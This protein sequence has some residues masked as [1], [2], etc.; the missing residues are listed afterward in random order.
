MT[1]SDASRNEAVDAKGRSSRIAGA[2]GLGYLSQFL[3]VGIGLWLTPFLLHRLGLR[4][5][6]LWLLALQLTS[7]LVLLDLG[8][9][10]LLPRETAYAVGRAGGNQRSPELPLLIGR[11][12]RIVILQLPLVAAIA[13]GLLLLLPSEWQPLRGPLCLIVGTFVAMFPI[14]LL[15]AILQGLQ[16]LPY[17]AKVSL[18]TW[19]LGTLTTVSLVFLHVG[20]YAVAI[21]WVVSQVTSALLWWVR[22]SFY[23]REVLPSTIPPVTRD[24]LRGWVR[25]GLWVSVAQVAQ[26]L[27]AGTDLLIIGKVLGPI[28]VVPYAVTGKLISV[29]AN[30]PQMVMQAAQPA[31]SEIKAT[32]DE[33]HRLVRMTIALSQ[34]MLLISGAVFLVVVVANKGFVSWW[35]DPKQYAGFSVTMALLVNMMLR[36]WNTTTVYAIFAFGN[37]RRIAITTLVD[38]LVTVVAAGTLVHFIGPV[39]AACGSILG[40]SIVS[41]PNNLRALVSDTNSSMSAVLRPLSPWFFRFLLLVVATLGIANSWTPAAPI[42]LAAIT[43]LIIGGYALTMWPVALRQP[44]GEYIRPRIHALSQR[45]LNV[46]TNGAGI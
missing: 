3:T 8:V 15:H 13:V 5:Y 44:L 18:A 4:D 39:G 19:S 14:R 27:L 37:E 28:A 30:Q 34:L 6:G 45:V 46:R 10:A 43:F 32:E 42:G 26:V 22:I 2:V 16:E 20:L 38:G 11:T 25:S 40:V 33:R 1:D 12:L 21:G 23:H 41:L 24:T 29:L 35:V 31:L 36:H 9:V 7:Y 17:L